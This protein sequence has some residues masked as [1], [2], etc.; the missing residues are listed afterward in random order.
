MVWPGLQLPCTCPL[1][2]QLQWPAS[3]GASSTNSP[4]SATQYFFTG[5]SI[6]HI[7][8]LV[9]ARIDVQV[10]SAHDWT[11]TCPNVALRRSAPWARTS[12]S[13]KY[14]SLNSSPQRFLRSANSSSDRFPPEAKI[15]AV[16][17][18]SH[19]ILA[20]QQNTLRR[21]ANAALLPES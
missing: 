19:S 17:Q 13:L 21:R 14:R 18:P 10:A 16:P 5:S 9:A 6:F 12:S 4:L 8:K 15:P 1:A 2:S 7:V 3:P 11:A 20:P